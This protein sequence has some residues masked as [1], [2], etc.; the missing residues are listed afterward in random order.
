[1]YVIASFIQHLVYPA[2][3]L[4]STWFQHLVPAPGLSSTWFIQHLVYP[5]P[6]SGTWFQHL[7]Q[8]PGSGTWFQHLVPAPGS[9]TWFRHLVPAPGSS[10]WFQHLVPAPS[11]SGTY[12]T[13]V[14]H[15]II[16]L[17][18]CCLSYGST[19]ALGVMFIRAYTCIVCD[20]KYR[21]HSNF[22][23]PKL[24]QFSQIGSHPRSLNQRKV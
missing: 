3:G 1:M 5:A 16:S 7:V 13:Y 21:T 23:G 6:G 12:S 2:P 20:I 24:S 11:V 8:A 14:V 4:S 9:S 22:R 17:S 18:M 10:T 15:L 19:I